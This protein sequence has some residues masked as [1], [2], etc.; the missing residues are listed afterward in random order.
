[1]PAMRRRMMLALPRWWRVRSVLKMAAR[2]IRQ[3]YEPTKAVARIRRG[4]A[5]LEIKDSLFCR[6]R[7]PQPAPLCDFQA[8]LI[9]QMLSRFN[10]PA[11]FR[12]EQCMGTRGDACAVAIDVTP[13]IAEMETG[14]A[15]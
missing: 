4:A 14:T 10:L 2:T 3:G 6:V 5:R 15:A 8:A 13:A 1:M 11:T 9:V 12:I 7:E